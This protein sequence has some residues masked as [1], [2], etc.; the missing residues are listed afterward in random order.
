M[1]NQTDVDQSAKTVALADAGE[2]VEALTSET[3]RAILGRI[4]ES[5][6]PASDLA[7]A[8]DISVQNASYHLDQLAEVDVVEVVDRWY[9]KR[10]REMKVYGPANTPLVIV[11]GRSVDEA[12]I[13]RMM[14]TTTTE[15]REPEDVATDGG[16][17]MPAWDSS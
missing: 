7:E 13:E 3:A 14:T 8:L 9:S 2:V 6:A 17:D 1:R 12:A 15:G 11:A 16:I 5:P 4:T 10:G